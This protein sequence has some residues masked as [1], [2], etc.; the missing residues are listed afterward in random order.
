M[1]LYMEKADQAGALLGELD[2]DCW[3]TFVRETGERPDPGIDLVLGS[4]LTWTSALI[5]G[6]DGSRTAIVGRYDVENVRLSGVFPEVIGY[7]EDI[8]APLLAA[9][10]KL[11]PQRIGLNYS[12]DSHTADGLTY[13]M[14]QMLDQILADTPYLGRLDSAGE[15]LS[16]LR[17]RKTPAEQARVSAA[18]AETE[19]IVGLVS[20]QIRPGVSELELADFV[21]AEFRRRGLPSSWD[22]GYCPTVNTG[23]DSPL[24]H[25]A[26][27]P[28][29][30]VQPGHLVH[31]DLGV[32][33]EEYCSDIQRMWYV[34][35]PGESAPPAE[36]QRAW[37]TVIAAIDAGAAALRPGVYGWQVDAAARKVIVDAG[38]PEYRHALGHGLG[39]A[40]HDGGPLLGPRWARYGSAPDQL[41]EVGHIYTLELGV[42]TPAGY[43][44]LE[45]D[46]VVTAEGCRFLSS[47]QRELML[48]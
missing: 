42:P 1:T 2:L 47:Y 31:M 33:K 37:E 8:S 43:L 23:P 48:I 39:R 45:E 32:I 22:W 36:V 38:Y 18:I 24:G 9:L 5:F 40:C 27:Q 6:K 41:V 19:E 3:L 35:R 14:R 16:R 10:Q 34:L 46:V 26:P 44:A 7:D 17:A 13:G 4:S 11:D 28:H 30:T 12:L 25:V 15:L 20:A 21:H 29:I